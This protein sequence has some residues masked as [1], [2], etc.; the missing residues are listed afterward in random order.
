MAEELKPIALPPGLFRAG[1]QYQSKGRW[2]DGHLVRFIANTIQ[3][4]GGW[5][6]MPASNNGQIATLTGVPRGAVAWRSDSGDTIVGAGTTQ[7]LYVIKG[8]VR[9]DVTPAGFVTGRADSIIPGV[10]G[11]GASAYG[12]GLYGAGPYGE[13]PSTGTAQEADTW[14]LDVFGDYLVGVSTSDRKFYVWQGATGT[15]A[16]MPSGA[17]TQLRG[18]VCTPER[19]VFLLG[20]NGNVRSVAWPSQETF[21]EFTPTGENTAGDFELTTNGALMS[22]RRTRKETLLWT[23]DDVHTATY[24]GGELVYRFEQAGEKCG[25]V[26]PNACAVIDTTAYWM[27]KNSFYLYDGFV[28]PLSSDVH[29]YVFRDINRAQL[30]KVFAVTNAEFGEVTWYY[31][32]AGSVENDRY[33][34]YNFRE[35]H[36]AF[37]QMARSAGV[38]AGATR[39]PVLFAPTGEPY[40][41]EV[42]E[43]RGDEEPY[44]ESGPFE[45][46][47]GDRVLDV[48]SLVPDERTLGDVAATFYVKYYPMGAEES[49]GPYT[50]EELTDVRFSGREFR[51]RLVQGNEVDWRIGVM[52]VGIVPQGFR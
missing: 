38:D 27:G 34:T 32:S 8:G 30:A 51:L 6:R 5:R 25:I 48:Q 18:V 16:A 45:L 35:G 4:I 17:P 2:Y 47:E 24:I 39:Y 46:G 50:L 37:G 19:F 29:D 43:D 3:P 28:K 36:W 33:V 22:G 44:L 13:A 7:K 23:D 42:G 49:Y 11:Q 20:A 9:Y 40:E 15:P 21:E 26:A 52:R 31:P 12:S 14:Q 41:H 1:T 10:S